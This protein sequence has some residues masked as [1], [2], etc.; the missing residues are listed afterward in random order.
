MKIYMLK[1]IFKICL[2]III[3]IGGLLVSVL[4]FVP[5]ILISI[6]SIFSDKQPSSHKTKYVRDNR[7]QIQIIR[8]SVR[9]YSKFDIP[10]KKVRHYL[11][12][13]G[14]G[15]Q[16]DNEYAFVELEDYNHIKIQEEL[17][18]LCEQY[19]EEWKKSDQDTYDFYKFNMSTLTGMEFSLRIGDKFVKLC[20]IRM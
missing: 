13:W 18:R 6:Y 17:D 19:P 7:S 11:D 8:D 5:S 12:K 9:N 3:A 16:I 14:K 20:R 15:M 2:Y 1:H 4:L 10:I